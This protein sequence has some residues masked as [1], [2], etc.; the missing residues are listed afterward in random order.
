[1]HERGEADHELIQEQERDRFAGT[2]AD[3]DGTLAEGERSDFD[4][5]REVGHEEERDGRFMR[6]GRT[7]DARTGEARTDP[8]EPTRRA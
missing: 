1:M 4:Q 8:A 2:S 3:R 7:E 6:D 5:G